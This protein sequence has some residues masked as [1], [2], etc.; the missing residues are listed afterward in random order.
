MAMRLLR[1][2]RVDPSALAA[3]AALT[4]AAA[5]AA[6]SIQLVDASAESGLLGQHLPHAPGYFLADEWIAGGLAV[7][8]FDRDGWPDVFVLGGG[9][10]PDQLFM[11]QGNGTFL[12]RASQRGVAAIHC[13]GS[14]AVLDYDRDGRLDLYVTS[15]GM[16][17][18][19]H[20]QV[21]R[22]KLYRNIGTGFVDVAFSAAVRHGSF[23]FPNPTGIAVGD[24]DLDGDL[25]M[26]VSAWRPQANGNRLFTN[27]GDGTF[28][29]R[30]VPAQ[31][32][33]PNSWWFQGRFADVDGDA[34]PELLVAGDF[35]TSRYFVNDRDGTFSD[36]TAVSGTGLDE[37]GMGQAFGDLDR[38]GLLDWYVTSIHYEDP[39]AGFR[40]GNMLY[41][42]IAPH[43][44]LEEGA[45]RGCEDGGWGWG[46]VAVDLD[47]DGWEDL[48]EVN[49]RNAGEWANEGG[50][51]F[52]NLGGG[53]F[54]EI[55]QAC[56]FAEPGDHRSI[57]WL[58]FDRDGDL[59]LVVQ[60]NAGAV[61]L[62]RNDSP[63]AGRWLQ[64]EF[65][66]STNPRIAPDG[67]GTRVIARAGKQEWMRVMDGSPSYL[68]TSELMVHFGL[69]DVEVLDEL[70]IW[71]P[72]GQ[73][74][75]L[76]DVATNQRLLLEAPRPGDLDA[77]GIVGPIDLTLLLAAWGAVQDRAGLAAD[78]DASGTV[79]AS[80]LTALLAAWDAR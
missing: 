7:G 37:N 47:Q 34:W 44:F 72:R 43:R 17:N 15:S 30:L 9:G 63:G 77:D 20:G 54:E 75:R 66:A 73:V 78:I 42:G 69:G 50:K 1:C 61:R 3:V 8:D 58:D 12:N 2:P 11:N 51:V 35:G 32:A 64:V 68:A 18:D 16:A 5:S 36:Q 49:G 79:A 22:H 31:V 38:D 23:S 59:D 24:V 19:N 39:P 71:W 74:Q 29:D 67:F 41:R 80:D 60:A 14:A 76:H 62:H 65:D 48:V 70:E 40:N 27:L 52:R 55:S 26:F 57:A 4:T 53:V 45:D 25:D 6:Q 13:G 33:T 56:G 28:L 10:V 21:G 46:A